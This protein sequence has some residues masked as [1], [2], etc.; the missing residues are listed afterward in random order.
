MQLGSGIAV[1]WHW[2]RLAAVSL[3]QPLAWETPYAMGVALKKKKKKNRV[4]ASG[5]IQKQPIEVH[6]S[7]AL[8]MIRNH[9]FTMI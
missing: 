5:I 8:G 3:I 7:S 2:C 6:H 9:F 4:A 1:I